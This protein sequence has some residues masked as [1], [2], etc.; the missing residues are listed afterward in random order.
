MERPVAAIEVD[1]ALVDDIDALLRDG[2]RGMVLNLVA[3]LH[4]A[5]LAQLLQHLPPDTAESLF[6]WLPEAKAGGALPELERARRSE[7]LDEMSAAQ[8]VPLLDEID[9]DDAADVLADLPDDLAERVLP[10]LEDAAEVGQ[11][12]HFEEDSAG[13]LMETDY[14]AV[15]DTA[16]VGEATEELRRCAEEVD[17]VYVVYV[18]D[19]VGHL[20]GLVDLKSLVLARSDTPITSVMRTDVITVEPE[21]DQEDAARLMERYDLVALPVVRD[22]FLL[23]R[24]TID[25]IVDVIRDEAEEDLQRAS[26]IAGDE[27]ISASVFDISKGRLVWLLIGLVGAYG[28]GLVIRGF[29]GALEAAAVLAMFIPIV[30]AM[31]GNAGIQSS[32][33]AVQGLASGDLWSSD[34]PRRIAKELAVALI[35][36][37]ALALA[38]GAIVVAMGSLGG[39]GDVDTPQLA[40]TS[41]L[42]LLIVIVLATVLGATIPLLL[43]RVGI[44]PALAT[45]PF[46]TTSNDII[47]LAVFFTVASLLYL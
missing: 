46:I 19:A 30:M 1:E 12:L 38:L 16:T 18:R 23:G 20:V 3:D 39:L 31:A 13:G 43:D 7:L 34:V 24:I 40:L 4:P 41:G 22:G 28:S 2:Q 42:S 37:V 25:D 29:E 45:G 14:V 5:D 32:A 21:L 36:G 27:E 17:P 35:N 10:H 8:L 6:G 15:L 9:T 26:G 44:D 47:G 33:I 11:L